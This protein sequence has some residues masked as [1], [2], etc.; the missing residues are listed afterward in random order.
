MSEESFNVQTQYFELTPK[1]ESLELWEGSIP[2]PVRLAYETYGE[3]NK[4]RSNA[5]ILFHAL[6]GSQHAAGI[7]RAVE[8][9]NDLWTE[10]LHLGWWDD[11]IGP[12]KALDTNKYFVI[13]AN[14]IGGCYGSTGPRHLHPD[15]GRPFGSSFPRVHVA[16]QCH[17]HARLLDHLGIETCHAV[18]GPSVGGMAATTF[19]TLFPERTRRVVSIAGSWK[20]TVLNRILL[21]EQIL[22]IE[23]DPHFHGGDYYQTEGPSY[24]LALAR[25]IS[26]KTFV[27]LDAIERRASRDVRQAE[28]HFAWYVIRDNVQS[29]M[30]HQ[31]K[32]FIER[33]DANTYLRFCEMWSMYDPV[34]E[35]KAEDSKSLLKR[36]AKAK[37]Q[38]LV[39]SIDSDFCF[40]PEE[41][42]MLA[43]ELKRAKVRHMHLTV[44]SEKGH[45][46]FL[47]EPWLFGP[48]LDHVLRD[49]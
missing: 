14:Y 43:S 2:G 48:H 49:R 15:T 1:G 31:G 9:D 5:V 33:F 11:Y 24:G 42:E 18:I 38:F 41:Q 32:K 37:Q 19:A 23:N 6:S 45:D 22:A 46:S 30:I 3:L 12:G 13:C 17:V 44:H 26:H 21:F 10:E 40:Y 47:L 39:F 25:M 34:L 4:D 16:D 28:S 35:G 36:C 29:Y 7:N 27:H 8:V 20:T